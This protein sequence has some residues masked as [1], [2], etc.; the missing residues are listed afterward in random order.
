MRTPGLATRYIRRS[1]LNLILAAVLLSSPL[2]GQLQLPPTLQPWSRAAS[3]S[4]DGFYYQ[5]EI[6][7]EDYPHATRAQVLRDIALARQVGAKALRFGVSWLETEPQAGQYDWSK[8]DVIINTAHQQG[9]PVIPYICY[10]PQ[11]AAT[12]PNNAEF[13]NLPPRNAEW[14]ARFASEAATRYKGKVLAWGLWNE[15]D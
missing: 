13:W 15:P 14:F 11:W 10:T 2:L 4:A 5:P 8:L 3:E 7:G 9:M 12:D 6:I 1:A